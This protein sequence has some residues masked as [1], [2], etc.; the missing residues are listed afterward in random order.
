MSLRYLLDTNLI[1]EP[2]KPAPRPQVIARLKE[3]KTELATASVV[4]HEAWFGCRRLPV[5]TRRAAIETYLLNVVGRTIP[6]L[7]YDEAAAARHA[8]ERARL[9]ALGRP[10]VFSDGQIAAIA[11]VHG[12][13]LVTMSF[14]D[15]IHFEGLSIEDWSAD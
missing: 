10:P 9:T 12:L 2:L 5:S 7:P 13:I 1:S 3:H 4:W 11:A 6:I 8:V 14:S 15:F